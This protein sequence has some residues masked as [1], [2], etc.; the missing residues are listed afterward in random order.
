[1]LLIP[2]ESYAVVILHLNNLNLIRNDS[3]NEAVLVSDAAR[4]AACKLMFERLWFANAFKRLAHDGQKQNI[5][6]LGDGFVG[7]L[8]SKVL[9]PRHHVKEN[10]AHGLRA[11]RRCVKFL[12]LLER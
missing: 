6:P 1:M 3:I 5:Q 4:P 2:A 7:L 9:L 12:Q 11:L 10:A 8:P